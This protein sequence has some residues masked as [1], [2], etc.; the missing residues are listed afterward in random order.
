V[1]GRFAPNANP[2]HRTSGQEEIDILIATDVLSEGLN[3][4]DCD[5]VINYDLH[6]NPVRLIQRFGRI[7]RIGSEHEVI[8]GYN[9]LPEKELEKNLG[10]HEKLHRRIQEIHATIGEDAAILEPEEQVNVE[11]MYAIYAEGEVGRHEDEAGPDAYVDLNE[12]LEMIRQ[13]REDN[14]ALYQRIVDMR[15]GVRCGYQV[16]R[17]GAVVLC[18]AGQYQQLMLLDADGNVISR[19]IPHIL[20]LMQCEPETPAQPLPAGHNEI[21]MRAKRRFE[22]EVQSRRAEQQHTLSLTKAQQYVLAELHAYYTLV[23]AN[24]QRQIDGLDRVFRRPL[25]RPGVQQVLRQLRKG[26]VTGSALV[27]ALTDLVDR[28]G[29]D[30]IPEPRRDQDDA[31][32][33][34]PH[35]VCSEALVE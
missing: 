7:D 3:L 29:L 2:Q 6:W 34:L 1:V 27:E 32:D 4:Q 8:Y 35:I 11:A 31:N 15:D 20:Y 33:S 17:E 25:A 9:F 5:N 24:V 14:P 28:Y 22:R 10:L 30:Q 23:D 19:D 18:R 13:I 12:A 16:G 21:V 26:S